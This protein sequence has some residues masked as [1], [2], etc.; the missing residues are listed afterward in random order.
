MT[1]LMAYWNISIQ[2]IPQNPRTLYVSIFYMPTLIQP[3]G[4]GLENA[5]TYINTGDIVSELLR[6]RIANPSG[7]LTIALHFLKAKLACPTCGHTRVNKDGM[8]Y[9]D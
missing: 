6:G 8:S 7:Y 2:N 3:N 1:C 4:C 5:R 9:T